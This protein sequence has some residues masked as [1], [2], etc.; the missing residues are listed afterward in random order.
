MSVFLLLERTAD[1]ILLFRGQ[2]RGLRATESVHNIVVWCLELSYANLAVEKEQILSLQNMIH[3]LQSFSFLTSQWLL[4]NLS[5]STYNLVN[6]CLTSSESRTFRFSPRSEGLPV[7][8]SA[9]QAG[10]NTGSHVL[11]E[12]VQKN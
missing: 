12:V 10:S 7:K 2:E 11:E 9:C 1:P 5:Q 3:G 4:W 8:G 6:V